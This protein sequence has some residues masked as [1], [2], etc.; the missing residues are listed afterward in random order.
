MLE[1]NNCTKLISEHSSDQ[2]LEYAKA[3]IEKDLNTSE[4]KNTEEYAQRIRVNQ[5]Y[6]EYS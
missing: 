4:Y 5:E 6:G 3:I 1:C 2:A